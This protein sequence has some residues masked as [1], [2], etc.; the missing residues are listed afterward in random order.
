MP[1]SEFNLRLIEEFRANE[2]RLTL[3]LGDFS[4]ADATMLLLNT[5]G[6]KTGEQRVAPMGYWQDGDDA[7]V[8]GIDAGSPKH[9]QWYWNL[10]ACPDVTVELGAEKYGAR[11]TVIHGPERERLLDKFIDQEPRMA[12]VR[13]MARLVPVVRL[14]RVQPGRRRVG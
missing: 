5:T 9:P 10:L 7:Y 2:G 13:S 8:L 14:D 11:A 4:L 3:S 6:A 1:H 12:F